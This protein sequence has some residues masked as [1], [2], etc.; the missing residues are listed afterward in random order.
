[1]N[2]TQST[3]S[4]TTNSRE[5]WDDVKARLQQRWGQID[6]GD[7]ESSGTWDDLLGR[8]QAK[9][10]EARASIESFASQLLGEAKVK[11]GDWRQYAQQMA[12]DAR[13]RAAGAGTYASETA[14]QRSGEARDMM[15]EQMEA[16]GQAVRSKPVTALAYAFGLGALVGVVLG[17]RRS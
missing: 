12:D 5:N 10:G 4:H 17:S 11:A 8:I 16:A 7:F 1:M 14:R 15:H 3:T 13:N 2:T 6:Q 9:T